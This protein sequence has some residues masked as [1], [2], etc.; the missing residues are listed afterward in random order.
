MLV[1]MQEVMNKSGVSFGTS[2]ARGLVSQMTDRVCYI[3]TRAFLASIEKHYPSEKKVA[4]A[5]DLRPSTDRILKA[6]FRASLDQGF[7]FVYGGK[8]PSPAIAL[9]GIQNKIPSIMVTGS[10][11]PEDRN[12]IKFNHPFGEIS[13]KDEEQIVLQEVQIEE[14]LFDTQGFFVESLD[15][16]S[17]E[18]TVAQNYVDRY[19]Q[20]F[21]EKA[22][23]GLSV[24][25]YQHS[26]V[27][28]DLLVLVLEKLGAYVQK[29]GFSDVFVP[30][31]TEA[32][33]NEDE[34]L[35][36]KWIQGGLD[37]IV[38][39]DGDSDRPLL[40]DDMGNWIRGDL[41]GILTAK[42]LG[43]QGIATPVSCN[44]ALEKSKAFEKVQRTRIGSPYVIA[45]MEKLLED[46]NTVVG[47]EANGG[48]LLGSDIVEGSKLLQKLPTR[49]AFLPII[50]VLREV[51]KQR[52]N[53][54]DLLEDLPTRFTASDRLKNFPN[55]KSASILK[56]LKNNSE[57]EKIFGAISGNLVEINEV[58]GYR[59]TFDS[60][61][62][63]HLRPSGNAPE[64]RCYTEA[65][66]EERAKKILVLVL[67]QVQKISKT[68]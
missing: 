8:S 33:R 53:I 42:F 40:S 60:A 24:G 65:D 17:V 27:G 59:M 51:I 2:G 18:T 55:K 41:L 37:A 32:I 52:K 56:L 31:D 46:T 68:L 5:V 45:G 9:Y 58:D 38:S 16:P 54:S 36:K 64:F 26:A 49:D 35:A 62:I 15:L 3:Y 21:G 63:I 12:G 4:V 29:L 47:Y 19:V 66:T 48:F 22:L 23:Q 61:E 34:I 6:I 57:A 50:T 25:V 30:V 67:E 28:R 1:L 44:T 39:T 20:F 11:I 7:E 10:H 43:A 14:S 13:K